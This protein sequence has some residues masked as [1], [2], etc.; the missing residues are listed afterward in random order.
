MKSLTTVFVF[1]NWVHYLK[2]NLRKQNSIKWSLFVYSKNLPVEE[3][4]MPTLN[5]R[6]RDNRTF[7]RRPIVGVHSVRALQNYLCETPRAIE[8][9]DARPPQK[10]K[11]E[12]VQ[13]VH[14]TKLFIS[15]MLILLSW[16]GS[17]ILFWGSRHAIVSR[18]SG[19]LFLE[20]LFKNL[21]NLLV[22]TKNKPKAF[23]RVQSSSMPTETML[24]F[25]FASIWF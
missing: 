5:I 4:Y 15:C 7:G 22:H 18:V 20:Y 3:I 11:T 13:G 1:E 2:R 12:N 14:R 6:V 25:W 9:V 16:R 21:K 8:D 10:G 17:L 19:L 23:T 24:C